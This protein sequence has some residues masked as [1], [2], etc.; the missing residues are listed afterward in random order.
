MRLFRALGFRLAIGAVVLVVMG[1]VWVV[2]NIM[3]NSARGDAQKTASWFY[4]DARFTSFDA[5]LNNS[6][7]Y[8]LASERGQGDHLQ[9][10]FGS[11]DRRDFANEFEG[12]GVLSPDELEFKVSEIKQQDNDGTTAHI[13]VSGKIVPMEMKRGKTR[14]S[15]SDDTFESFDH[16]VTLTK[17]DGSWYVAEVEP[18][19]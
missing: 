9:S 5:F 4:D 14:Y 13:L 6:K 3:R 10:A 12:D 1:G 7:D 17:Q 19:N 16:L 15:F 2:N 8:L 11:L 18:Q